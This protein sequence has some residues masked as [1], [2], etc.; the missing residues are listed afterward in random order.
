[1]RNTGTWATVSAMPALPTALRDASGQRL[2]GPLRAGHGQ[3]RL[4][5]QQWQHFRVDRRHCGQRQHPGQPLGPLGWTTP[6]RQRQHTDRLFA[7]RRPH[8][9]VRLLQRRL[10][11][12]YHGG[13]REPDVS[14]ER[15]RAGGSDRRRHSLEPSEGGNLYCGDTS[16]ANAW[17]WSRWSRSTSVPATIPSPSRTP[18]PS[19]RCRRLH[20]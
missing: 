13:W 9:P 19:R 5:V 4:D 7:A 17:S 20:R 12:H 10:G 16:S 1:M 18:A 8:G 6:S 11:G 15:G 3:L 2:H 14:L